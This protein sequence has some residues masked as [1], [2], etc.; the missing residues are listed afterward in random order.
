MKVCPAHTPL[1]AVLLATALCAVCLPPASAL[2]EAGPP[3]R[4][5]ISAALHPAA[6]TIKGTNTFH[7]VNRSPVAAEAF[8]LLAYPNHYA[9][10]WTHVP[11]EWF[12]RVFPRGIR[13]A[14]MILEGVRADGRACAFSEAPHPVLRPGTLVEVR[15]P[16]PLPSGES[17]LIET[18]FT[19]R[20]PERFGP[21]GFHAGRIC[22]N[23]GWY[24]YLPARGAG[25]NWDVLAP[26]PRAFF[27][28]RIR[29]P[30]QGHAWLN[31]LHLAPAPDG[32]ELRSELHANLLTLVFLPEARIQT[33]A[34]PHG[35]L[36]YVS[37]PA[38]RRVARRA[39]DVA[40]HALSALDARR[41]VSGA[42]SF[43]FIEVPLR[44]ELAVAAAGAVLVSDRFQDVFP[45]ARAYHLAPVVEALFTAVLAPATP[46]GNGGFDWET[47]ALAWLETK[48]F[49]NALSAQPASVAV[50]LRPLS[51]L[52][53]VDRWLQTRQFPFAGALFNDA[54]ADDELSAD[55]LRF[56]RTSA[57]GRLLAEKLRDL[58]GTETLEDAAGETL[59]GLTTFQ[60][61]LEDRAGRSLQAFLDQWTRPYPSVNY[62]FDGLRQTVRPDGSVQA[63]VRIRQTGEPVEEPVTVEVRPLK[64][65]A[66]RATWDGA[67]TQGVATVNVPARVLQVRIDP[68]R[69]LY[70]TER[71]DNRRLPAPK[72]LLN[73]FHVKL[74]LNGRDH[75]F[76]LGG[77]IL[78]AGDYRRRYRFYAFAEQEHNGIEL[79]RVQAFGLRLNEVEY[80]QEVSMGFSF[81]DLDDAFVDPGSAFLSNTGRVSA[82]LLGYAVRSRESSRNPL[83]GWQ[84]LLE[85]ELG[86]KVAGSEYRYWKA[87]ARFDTL[88]PIRRDDRLLALRLYA[89]AADAGGTPTQLLFDLGGF[90]AVRG[91]NRGAALGNHIW[92]ATAE[93]RHIALRN[94]SLNAL[95]LAWLRRLQFAAYADA[96]AVSLSGRSLFDADA[97]RCG[98]GAGLRL[99]VDL[100]G[101]FPGVW[102]F[103]V[104]TELDRNGERQPLMFYI[105]V[106]QSF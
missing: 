51:F 52:P 106:G 13:D 33:L 25:G 66:R 4:Y 15:L 79:Q 1:P 16:A 80:R 26:P 43:T 94:L 59:R 103:D 38:R 48:R 29:M 105:G 82:A 61:A 83:S 53:T 99:H 68:D 45:P 14:A 17:T 81:S 42:D 34:G 101:A 74:D 40:G 63:N 89:G 58:L 95:T 47:E 77:Q 10:E 21:F 32:R 91:I 41:G 85:T 84:V 11:D 70:E 57:H 9:S 8:P 46:A 78:N 102:R 37:A 49:W 90:D 73:R 7:F 22:L 54:Y 88:I 12:D 96:G 87:G 2:S 28:A 24:P 69:R 100:L 64:G 6:R 86:E 27:S 72:L 36:H 35:R 76:R 44:R 19:L 65:P 92:Q 104:A 30:P 50:Y 3:T 39:L 60:Q 97:V 20:I 18:A 93:Y 55:I 62:R 75:E 71:S 67:G 5:S 56:N 23:G 31:G 98:V